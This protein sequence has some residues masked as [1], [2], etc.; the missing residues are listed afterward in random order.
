MQ[1]SINALV[2]AVALVVSASSFAGS[3]PA[4]GEFSAVD[5]SSES[6]APV[7]TRAAVRQATVADRTGAAYANGEIVE[8]PDTREASGLTRTEVRQEGRVAIRARAISTG[9][10]SM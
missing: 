2:A 1:T 3:M 5:T 7:V 4:A 10:A 6:V 8:F 9:D